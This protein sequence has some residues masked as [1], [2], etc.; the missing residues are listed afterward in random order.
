MS[1][2]SLWLNRITDFFVFCVGGCGLLSGR[3]C[4]DCLQEHKWR[5]YCISFRASIHLADIDCGVGW[6]F[7]FYGVTM[8]TH[9]SL[10]VDNN[11]SIKGQQHVW[12]FTSRAVWRWPRTAL[13]IGVSP[14]LARKSIWAPPSTRTRMASP[15]PGSHCTARDRAVS[16]KH[17]QIQIVFN[18]QKDCPRAG[19]LKL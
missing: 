13:C 9:F 17:T 6:I 10:W 11:I 2:P 16:G 4:L 3:V 15:P 7:S 8:K 5:Q 19:G 1:F 14:S 12:M 18:G